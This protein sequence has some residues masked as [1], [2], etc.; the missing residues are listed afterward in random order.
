MPCLARARPDLAQGVDAGSPPIVSEPGDRPSAATG[1][2]QDRIVEFRAEGNRRVESQAIERALKNKVGELF[3]PELTSEDLRALW[4]LRYFS[5]IQ[6]LI[7]RA[8]RGIAYVV[9]VVERPAVREVRLQGNEELSKEDFKEAIDIK[10]HSILDLDA[11]R[12]NEKKIQEKYVEKGFFLAEVT[13]RI[14]AVAASNEVDV[15]FVIREHSKVMVKEINFLGVSKVPLDELKGAMFT[16]EGGYLSFLTSEGTYREE[17]FQRDLTILQAVYYDRGFI[18]V[19]IDKPLVSI[20]PDK[21]F[22]YI[23]LKVEEGE[24]YSIGKLDFSGDLLIAKEK[25]H[26]LMTSHPREQFNRSKLSKDIQAIT[27]VYYDAG[28]AYANITPVT[29]VHSE[30]RTIDLTFDIQKGKQVYIERIDVVGNS[31]TRDKVIRREVRVYEGEL[32]SGTGL[33]RSKERVT[34]LGFFE[35][36]EVQH[37]PGSDDS[38][39]V[40]QVDV[41]EKATG[42]F[43]VGLGFSS[44]E[45]F[46]FTAQVAQNNLLGWG[47]TASV[48]AQISSLRSFFQF[49]FFDPYFL[50]TDYL[51][52]TDLFRIQAD[53]GGFLRTSTGGDVN[54]GYRFFEDATANL[55]YTREYVTVEPS[56]SFN[57][58]P[59]A[60]RL[61]RSGITSSVR[62]SLQWDRRDNRL[63]PS[64]GHLLF[65]SVELAPSFL[66]ST[67]LFARYNTYARYYK[68]LFWGFVFKVNGTLGYIQTLDSNSPV[69]ISELFYLGGINSIRGYPLRT[70]SP[71]ILVPRNSVPDALVDTFPV[72]GNKQA[73]FNFELEFPIIEKV[74]IKGVLFYDVGNAFATNANFFED[75]QHNL[76][77]GM[78]HS[79]GFGFR[80]F[81][82]IGPL[83]FEWG[84]PLNRRLEID[85]PV[86]F[87]FTIGNFF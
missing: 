47:Q 40:V 5:D 70:I 9:R 50:D 77:L 44:V 84:F 56:R 30:D 51:F 23:T 32:F 1:S 65:G 45:N 76:P 81:S 48:S 8:A 54:L 71:T 19:K 2:E 33:R 11:V 52:S 75:K 18:N 36:V 82:P 10:A 61:R 49:S 43:Q 46:I 73:I 20:S 17:I 38:K 63:F 15:V 4:G 87:E 74:G 6:L 13:H 28:Y 67:F 55:T 66:G 62:L 7:Q 68:P 85:Q 3:N 60:N 41:K 35:T 83:R 80:W 16:R 78:F 59:L 86:Q 79:V 22:I 57:T 25:L 72:G 37:K 34:A 27:D 21:R 14:D 29:Q 42:T 39:V 64:K 58:I 24:T 53:F 69:P 31:K 26:A 12:Q